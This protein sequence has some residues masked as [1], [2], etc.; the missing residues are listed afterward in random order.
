M[1]RSGMTNTLRLAVC[2]LLGLIGCSTPDITNTIVSEVERAS[3]I[4]YV[5][6]ESDYWQS[7]RETEEIW[8]GDCED[9]AIYLQD[10]LA[11]RGV[12]TELVFG[13]VKKIDTRYHAWVE[14]NTNG[15]RYVLDATTN[16]IIANPRHSY[17]NE[18]YLFRDKLK[19]FKERANSFFDVQHP[20]HT[21]A[22][23]GRQGV[24][25]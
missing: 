9:Y 10:R 4:R 22:Q 25:P 5:A 21:V 1:K 3:R 8:Q 11:K 20:S 16:L 19:A 12:K 23:D 2:A 17:R 24:T 6:E 15:N 14:M 7:A 13:K 18:S